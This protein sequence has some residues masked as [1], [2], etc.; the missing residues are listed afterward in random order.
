MSVEDSVLGTLIYDF[1]GFSALLKAWILCYTV[2]PPPQSIP[3]Q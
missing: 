1:S 3:L 2:D